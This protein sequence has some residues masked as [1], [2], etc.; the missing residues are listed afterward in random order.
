MG[1]HGSGKSELLLREVI[2]AAVQ[3]RAEQL[4]GAIYLEELGDFTLPDGSHLR[5]I[6]GGGGG[7]WNPRDFAATLAITTS[8]DGPYND[9]EEEG[10]LLHYAY[11]R[12]PGDGKNRKC[13]RH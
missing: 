10:G 11:Q 6:D 5:L 3:T 1:D 2:A 7:I 8:P 12:G 13:E 9:R 4:G